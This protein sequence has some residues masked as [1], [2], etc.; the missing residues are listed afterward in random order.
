MQ[1]NKKN[2]VG[3]PFRRKENTSKIPI[4]MKLSLAIPLLLTATLQVNAFTFGQ[5]INLAKRN[6]KL[7]TALKDIQ[8]Q[9]G[10]NIFYSESLLEKKDR[11]NVSLKNVTLETALNKLLTTHQ[12]DYKIVDNNVI[13]SPIVR[14]SAEEEDKLKRSQQTK[15]SG[16]V[17]DGQGQP[18]SNVT[19]S[20]KGTTNRTSTEA[21]GSFEIAIRTSDAI[22]SFS[23]VGYNTQE[24]SV[25]NEKD[26]LVHMEEAIQN[27]DEVVVVGYG[28]QKKVNLTGAVDQVGE[29]VFENR[30][31]TNIAQGLVGAVPNLNIQMLGGKPTE[32]PDFNIRGTTSIGQGGSA[33]VLIDGVEGDPRMLNPN[34]IENIS[35]LKD[36][37]SASIYGARAA[38]GVVLITTKSAKEGRTSIT[39]NANMSI[40]SPTT[41][42][43]NITDSYPWA[44]G[45]SDAWSRWNDSGT[46][47][48]AINKTLPFSPEYLAEIKKRWEDPSLPRIDIDPNSGEYMYFYSTDWY[49]EL[50]KNNFLAH[51]HNIAVSGGTDKV[52]YYLSGRYNGQDGLFRYNSDNYGMYNLRGKGAIN[53]TS[54][55]QV[56]N[57]TEYSD[58]HYFQPVNVGEGSGI[59]RNIADEGHPLAPLLNPDGSLSF[60]AAY[61][62]GDQYIG[63]N[64]ID[65]QH[66]FLKNRTGAV[67]SFLDKKLNIRADFTFQTTD[68]AS[69]QNRVQVPY[70]RYEGVIGYTGT[71]TN[72]LEE[73]R[74]TTKYMATNVYADYTTMLDD[75]HNLSFLLGYNYEQSKYSNLTARR[76]GIVYPDANDI[77]LA[78][79]QSIVT[80]GGLK[81]WAI[82]GGFFRINYDFMERYL[83]EVN[84]RYDGSSKFPSDQQW[85]FFPSAS[86]GWRISEEP[87]WNVNPKYLS[88]VKIRASYG[89]LGNGNI[90]PY[91]FMENFSISQSG[92]IIAGSRPQKTEQPNVIPSGLTWEKSAT[93]N[94]GLEFALLDN[95][96]QFVA[97]Y[98]Q[99][100]TTDMFT[101]GP[102][103][104]AIFGTDVPKG[105]YA[106]LKTKGW[107]LNVSYKDRFQLNEKP[108]NWDVRFV[109]SDY[110]AEVTKY[111]NVDK[112]LT[113]YYVGQKI[114]EIWGYSVE[115]LF[116]SQEEI[117]N[118]PSQSNIPN[119]NTRKN[120]PG[121]LKIRDLDGDGVIY[122]G[123]NQAENSGDKTI[124]GNSSSRYSFGVNLGGEW[125]GIF[126]SA[127]FQG[128]LKQDWYPSPESRFW[129]QYNRPYNAYPRW[130][131]SNMFR[132][133]LGNFD[134]Y[135]PRLVGY[136]AQGDGNILNIPNDRYLQ[137]ASYIRLRNLQ[138]GYTLPQ[139]LS[140]K[141][142]ASS[143]K[144]YMSA[145]NLWT[146]SPMYKWTKD[147]DVT[148]IYGSD[149]DLSNGESGDGYNYPML[150]AVSFGLMVGF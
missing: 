32:S 59:W 79:G 117:D 36:A 85:A 77:N 73:R 70:S 9:S 47:P 76:N 8:R 111:N 21:D 92:R 64:G 83:L 135:L 93:A 51:D 54:W 145:E 138:V 115:G 113:D 114:G 6:I 11:I 110:T 134:A 30:P 13:L 33:L 131:E 104:P 42:P 119:T 133:E 69:Q 147:T 52:V 91:T 34:D 16:K 15:L 19:V 31:I 137:D 126:L 116:R 148:N 35:V 39:Y 63:R 99:R 68:I 90:D 82:A 27:M 1:S 128:V 72:D 86:A 50:Y 149:R 107:E 66:R 143:L 109:L 150:K 96:L 29:E 12:L 129:G 7:S 140:T 40:K 71:N 44:Q 38:F 3:Y 20:E 127:F 106:D 55:L 58:M 130:Q 84:G 146:W 10:Y 132:E 62:V 49:K 60:S 61:T 22:L 101:V 53:L 26:I 14:G 37:A 57:N 144:I 45:F 2:W 95:R 141:I 88:N 4:S 139:R 97:D 112:L 5:R 75:K 25:G 125:N 81:K 94:V 102:T 43:D 48:T 17:T 67:A 142:H 105:N 23:I 103:L 123:L 124:I 46:S 18:L 121:D 41:V 65:N 24:V 120:Y 108:F 136:I 98:Y 118:S 89:L 56:D 100:T 80:T 122:Q 28:Q 74:Q 78:L 87:F